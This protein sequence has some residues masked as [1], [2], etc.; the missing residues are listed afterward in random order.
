MNFA[1]S[2]QSTFWVRVYSRSTLILTNI[3]PGGYWYVIGCHHTVPFAFNS[4]LGVKGSSSLKYFGFRMRS[5]VNSSACLISCFAANVLKVKFGL[6]NFCSLC[7]SHTLGT[8][9]RYFTKLHLFP[10]V[11]SYTPLFLTTTASKRAS[12]S[13][14]HK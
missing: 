10:L 4:V 2:L 14:E 12:K 9:C 7:F 5:T 6:C 13:Y 3:V 1:V 11:L 8:I